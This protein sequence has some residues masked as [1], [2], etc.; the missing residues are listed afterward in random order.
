MKHH[1]GRL[2]LRLIFP[3]IKSVIKSNKKHYHLRGVIALQETE[4]ESQPCPTQSR[5]KKNFFLQ[6]FH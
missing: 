6:G 1:R 5:Q 4:V 3:Q 2:H